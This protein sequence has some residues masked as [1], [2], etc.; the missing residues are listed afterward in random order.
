MQRRSV[1]S[2]WAAGVHGEVGAE[3]KRGAGGDF[4]D[5]GEAGTAGVELGLEGGQLGLVGAGGIE[6]NGDK[7]Q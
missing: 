3:F 2:R 1:A 4:F 5:G 6:D 7:E